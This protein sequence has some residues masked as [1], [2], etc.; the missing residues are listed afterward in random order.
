MRA[1]LDKGRLRSTLE[2]IP[3]RVSLNPDA[4]LIGAAHM[5]A[6]ML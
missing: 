1:F 4:A 5:A 2:R 3:V 6:S